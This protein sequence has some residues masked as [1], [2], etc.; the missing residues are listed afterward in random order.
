MNRRITA[1]IVVFLVL[2]DV[3]PML[4]LFLVGWDYFCTSTTSAT[5]SS[6][7]CLPFL[8]GGNLSFAS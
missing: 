4:L 8:A 5:K 6:P 1:S 2:V 7:C 3:L